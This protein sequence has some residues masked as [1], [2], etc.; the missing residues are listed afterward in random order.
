MLMFKIMNMTISMIRHHD[1]VSDSDPR[2]PSI[3]Q[4]HIIRTV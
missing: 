2:Y 1:S 4:L 3:A